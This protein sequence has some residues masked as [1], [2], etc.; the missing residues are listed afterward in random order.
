MA[1][2]SALP[3][4]LCVDGKVVGAK[5]RV[6]TCHDETFEGVIFTLDAVANFLILEERPADAPSKS[7]TRIFQM[8]ALK[9]IEVVEKAPGDANLALPSVSEE[10][11]LRLEQKNKGIAERAL[12]SIGKGV[13]AEAQAIFDALNKTMPCVWE[14]Q[15]IRVMEDVLIKPPYEP[16]HCVSANTQVLARV[17]KV[18]EGEKNK[19]RKA[20]KVASS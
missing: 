15:S 2:S 6:T 18:L 14:G 20:Q 5:V 17:K 16:Q 9:K 7:K 4:E 19:L 13:S 12:A 10:D 11:L 3:S 8:E 1:T